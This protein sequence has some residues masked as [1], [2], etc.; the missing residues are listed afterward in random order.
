MASY[1][2][3]LAYFTP[4]KKVTYFIYL[5]IYLLFRATLVAYG[6]S[7]ARGQIGAT[8]ASLRHSHSKAGSKGALEPTPQRRAT[9]DP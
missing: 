8:D 5:F 3:H 7:Q 9:P 6:V 2:K 4:I 1:Y